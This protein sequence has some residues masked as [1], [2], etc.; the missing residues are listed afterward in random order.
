MKNCYIGIYWGAREET[1]DECAQKV[2]ET[3][4]YLRNVDNSFNQWFQTEK[5]R[6][7][8]V[9][10]PLN[11]SM[12]GIKDLL[13]SGRNFNDIGELLEDL[14][15][16]LYLKSFIDF[17]KSHVLSFSCGQFNERITNSVVLELSKEK[18]F[19]YLHQ[20]STLLRIFRKLGKI[21]SPDRGVVKCDDKDILVTGSYDG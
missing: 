20:T 12:E 21:W 10:A 3:F 17:S 11:I 8:Q 16:L 14:G 18:E 15:Y 19:S 7:G 6:K 1:V 13:L 5:P 2:F 4:A 9:V